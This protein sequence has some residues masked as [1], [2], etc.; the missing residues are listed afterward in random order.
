MY[1]MRTT[2]AVILVIL[3]V[4][5]GLATIE[6]YS[7]DGLSLVKTVVHFLDSAES[8]VLFV[9]YSLDEPLIIDKLNELV[10]KGVHVKGIVDDSSIFRGLSLKPLF[11]LKCDS[12]KALIHAKFMIVDGHKSIVS[13]GN[14]T[15]SGLCEDSNT[16]LYFDSEEIALGLTKFYEA[17]EKGMKTPGFS[18]GKTFFYLTPQENVDEILLTRILSAEKSI[19]FMFYA[20]TDPRFLTAFKYMA[21]K[22]VEVMGIVDDWN[23]SCSPLHTYFSSG[24]ELRWNKEKWLLHDKTL[25]IDDELVITGSANL[26][27]SA[28][29]KNRELVVIIESKNI[30]MRFMRH[31]SHLWEVSKHGN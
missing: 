6:Y 15:H 17:I 27:K 19:Y 11:N 24:I 31:F 14:F 29:S 21:S 30:A 18:E 8:T 16:L 25:I 22:G 10:A 28:W 13:T 3:T 7:S 26:T 4:S 2:F 9:A 5:L 1:S 12:S 23:I 20:F